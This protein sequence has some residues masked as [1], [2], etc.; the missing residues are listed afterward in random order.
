MLSRSQI[1]FISSLQQKKFRKEHGC[2]IAEGDT[3][4]EELLQSNLKFHS[5]FATGEWLQKHKPL[6]V[7]MEIL[8][9]EASE[10]ELERI[11]TLKT[12]NQAEAVL[13]IP[14]PFFDPTT[15]SEQLVL[16]VDNINDPGNLGTIVRTAD[17]FGIKHVICSPETVDLYNPKTVK[18]T[19]GSIARVNVHY[20]DLQETLGKLRSEIPVYGSLLGGEP[21]TE[22][23]LTKNGI[24]IIG[25]EAHGISPGLLSHITHPVRIPA[26]IHDGSGTKR[27]ES[28]NAAVAAAILCW[29]FRKNFLK[30]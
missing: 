2:F 12:P 17:W 30:N 9:F 14:I 26:L 8:A 23:V 27:P 3:L 16:M 13:Y 21:I 20:L 7:K 29:E 1:Q 15:A 4:V 28:L 18:A 5:I 25:S 19:M 22:T 24:I 11:S 6:I 10:N